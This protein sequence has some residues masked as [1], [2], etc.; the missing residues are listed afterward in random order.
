M[1]LFKSLSIDGWRQFNSINI[2]LS[3]QITILTGPNGTGKTTILNVLSHH[4]GWSLPFVSTPYLGKRTAERLWSDVYKETNVSY[5]LQD[6]PTVARIGSIKYDDGGECLLT[7]NV[8]VDANYQLQYQGI[9]PVAGLFVPSHRPVATYHAIKEIPTNPVGT[10][11]H[12]QQYQAIL[13]RAFGSTP[14][15][16]PGVIQKKSIISLGLFGEGNSA[17]IGN[18]EYARAYTDF[19]EKLR[20]VLPKEIGFQRIE[21]RMPEVVLI[22]ESG[23]FSLDAMSGGINALFGMVWQIFMAGIGEEHYVVIIDEPENHLHPAM[24]RSVLPSLAAAFPTTRF[25][26]STHSPFIVSSFPD[27]A[28]YGLFQNE[29]RRVES[30][31]I[32]GEDLSGSANSI[33]RDVLSVDSTVPLWVEKRVRSILENSANDEPIKR[34]DL[35]M[36]ELRRLGIANAISEYRQSN[37][38]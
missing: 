11:Q 6:E 16:N 3:R 18:L 30:K 23:D 34:A 28:V 37:T 26:V 27:A 38:K 1:A 12:F 17:V 35:V 19:Q 32:E 33:L 24:Q 21:I 22:T 14:R 29:E 9:R 25:V 8:F 36:E 20:V 4:F 7:T 10:Q 13:L 5:D 15:E 2:D 31:L